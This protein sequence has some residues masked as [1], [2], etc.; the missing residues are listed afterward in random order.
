[1]PSIQPRHKTRKGKRWRNQKPKGRVGAPVSQREFH[2]EALPLRPHSTSRGLYIAFIAP[3]ILIR[4]RSG[5]NSIIRLIWAACAGYRPTEF[6]NG[7]NDGAALGKRSP[8][9]QR[10]FQSG[11]RV[12]GAGRTVESGSQTPARLGGLIGRRAAALP[13]AFRSKRTETSAG[14]RRIFPRSSLA[15]RAANVWVLGARGGGSAGFVRHQGQPISKRHVRRE[16]R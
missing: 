5:L 4:G 9:Q 16:S 7:K 10:G 12:A 3:Q 1:M 14:A 13:S 6:G 2:A 15:D 8:I 11:R